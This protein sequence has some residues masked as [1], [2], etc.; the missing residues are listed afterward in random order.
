[1][2]AESDKEV[3]EE[4]RAPVVHLELH[5]SAALKGAAGADDEG[6]VVGSQLG[7]RVGS[8]G[9]GVSRRGEDG[10]ALDTGFFQKGEGVLVVGSAEMAMMKSTY[11]VLVCEAPASSAHPVRTFQ[12][13]SK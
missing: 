13:R 9:V 5:G 7:V 2:V 6:E 10:A 4:L 8:V 1:M 12:P 3:K 11:G